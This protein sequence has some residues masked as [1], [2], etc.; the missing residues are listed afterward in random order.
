MHT[1]IDC[2][3]TCGYFFYCNA[4]Q[5]CDTINGAMR[6]FNFILGSCFSLLAFLVAPVAFATTTIGTNISSNGSLTINGA[7]KFTS[8]AANNYILSTDASGNSTWVSVSNALTNAGLGVGAASGIAPLDSSSKVPMIN[9]PAGTAGGVATLDG[10]GKVPTSQ[11]PGV[12]L[13]NTYVVADEASMLA[14]TASQGD[15]AVRTD[16]SKTYILASEP[17]STLSNWVEILFSLD[18]ALNKANNLSDLTDVSVARTNLGLGTGSTPTFTGLTL[19]APLSIAN[20][21]TGATTQAGAFNALSPLTTK[22]DLLAHDGTN[23]VRLAVGTDGQFLMAD[24]S[25]ANGVKWT[26]SGASVAWGG[27]TG[28]LSDQ[29]DLGTALSG[30]IAASNFT[31]KGDVLFGT[32]SGAYSALGIGT[33]GQVLTADSTQTTG[34]KWASVGGT[35]TV[36]SVDGS[37]GTTGL[38]MSGGPITSSGTL[39]LGGTLVV[40]NGGTGATTASGARTSLGAA[41]SGAN[42]DITSLSGLTTALSPAQGGTGLTSYTTGDLL[43]A[44]GAT[45]LSALSDVALGSCLISG[46]VGAAPSWGSCS[47]ATFATL[48]G[49]TNTSAAMLVGTGSSLAPTGSGTLTANQF[50]GSGSTTNAVDLATAEVAGALAITNGGTGATTASGARSNLGAAASGANSD[51]TSLS[52]LT[53]ALSIAQ[54]G[55]GATTANAAL[56]AFLPTQTGNTGKVLQTDGSN[57]SW[58]TAGTGTV[59]SVNASGGT[60]GLSFSGG[61]VTSSGT[62]T[63]SGTLAVANGGTNG[64]ATPTA[65][66]VS[67]GT[68]SAYAFNSAG[69][70]GQLLRSAGSS[71]PTWTTATFPATAGTSGSVLTSDGTNWV[72]TAPVTGAN[73]ADVYDTT[74]TVAL[75]NGS[76]TNVTFGNT[77]L[78]GFTYCTAASTPIAACT[79]AGDLVASTAGTYRIMYW[80]VYGRTGGAGNVAVRLFKNNTS[81]I[82]NSEIP[83]VLQSSNT[84]QV[85]THTVLVTLAANDTVRMQNYASANNCQRMN[86]A[87]SGGTETTASMLITRFK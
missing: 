61:P 64:T 37:G 6:N 72:S 50:V 54:G 28:T 68:G 22:G 85:A 3:Q 79:A 25:E 65:G 56:N 86:G 59:T 21:G 74:A 10:T 23:N 53:T 1:C 63:L 78:D 70:T 80:G 69:S 41:A 8:G 52:G 17:A 9:L 71:A 14:L 45:T 18:A 57:T 27:I 49:G 42:S 36:T 39:T 34:V 19:S 47:S 77:T 84:P 73:Y 83:V 82:S 15:V 76:W 44:S 7:L 5:H 40:G 67:Y 20:G 24:S 13:T 29:T 55:T 4:F 30:K 12:S 11:L 48:A 32:G 66:A 60:T 81:V 46:G 75:T 31:A 33:D 62:L 26:T 58:V 87:V 35:G 38:T 2:K 51:I 16:E 43:Y